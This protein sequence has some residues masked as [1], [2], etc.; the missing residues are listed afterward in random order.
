M[1]IESNLNANADKC[2][3]QAK[4]ITKMLESY[5]IGEDLKNASAA[6]VR[7][8]EMQKLMNIM[9]SDVFDE[10]NKITL[11]GYLDELLDQDIYLGLELFATLM[12]LFSENPEF[13]IY[14]EYLDE[15]ANTA[16]SL[17]KT[18]IFRTYAKAVMAFEND[19]SEES[20]KIRE[21]MESMN[22]NL[23]KW[24]LEFPEE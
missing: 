12:R 20:K 4:S 10:Q 16:E 23:V 22:N 17:N 2:V 24:C 11:T 6:L 5:V 18:D 1:S 15:M 8:E 14:K 21:S 7:C 9:G 3:D 19:D 13:L